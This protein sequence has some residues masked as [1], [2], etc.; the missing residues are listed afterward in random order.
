MYEQK[1]YH[2]KYGAKSNP[3]TSNN[4]DELEDIP[5]SSLDLSLDCIAE[6]NLDDNEGKYD[7][8]VI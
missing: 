2:E 3:G 1:H 4:E 5:I 8:V 6:L 7:C